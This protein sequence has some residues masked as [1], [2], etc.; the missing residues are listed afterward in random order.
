MRYYWDEQI[1]A[2]D[3]TRIRVTQNISLKN[4]TENIILETWV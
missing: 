3:V 1:K 2:D 4:C